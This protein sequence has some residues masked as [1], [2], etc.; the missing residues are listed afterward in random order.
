MAKLK[1]TIVTPEQLAFDGETDRV[2]VRAALGE[3]T[4]LPGHIDCA[5]ALGDGEARVTCG[6]A[7]HRAHICGVMIYIS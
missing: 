2:M 5:A 1:L 3:M 4:V 6:G 7:V